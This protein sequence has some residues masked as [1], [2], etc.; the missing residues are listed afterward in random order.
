MPLLKFSFVSEIEKTQ[1]PNLQELFH[2]LEVHYLELCQMHELQRG[3]A[4]AQQHIM[5][6]SYK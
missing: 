4:T 5:I 2:M 6:H 3:D 1:T